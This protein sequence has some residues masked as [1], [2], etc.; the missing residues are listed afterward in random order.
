MIEG[1]RRVEIRVEAVADPSGAPVTLVGPRSQRQR[2]RWDR[3]VEGVMVYLDESGR[4]V[5]QRARAITDVIGPPRR[6]FS[7][8]SSTTA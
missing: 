3:A 8:G 6:V 7:S 1:A 2:L 4:S 5:P